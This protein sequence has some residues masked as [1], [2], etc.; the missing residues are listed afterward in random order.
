MN[1]LITKEI[2]LLLPGGIIAAAMALAQFVIPPFEF[3]GAVLLFIGMTVMAL[4]SIGRESSLNTFSSLLA[5][6]AERLRLWNV[7]LSVLSIMFLAA[8]IVWLMAYGFALFWWR[9][10]NDNADAAYYLFVTVCLAAVTTFSG[11]LWTTLLVRQVPAAFWLTLLAPATLCGF[12]AAFASQ[13]QPDSGVIVAVT[14]V[15]AIYSVG[16][17]FFARWL[18]L[19]AQDI[20]W[21]GGTLALPESK[22][23]PRSTHIARGT[24]KPKPLYALLKKEWQLQQPVT[25][26]AIG[27]LIL[28][29]GVILLR[30]YHQFPKDSAG[31][32]LTSIF[33]MLWLVL[34]VIAGGMAVAEERKLGMQEGQ[35]CLPRSRRIQFL[36]KAT[37]VLALGVGLGS[38]A[39]MLLEMIGLMINPSLAGKI[40]GN[41][42]GHLPLLALALVAF[43][44]GLALV[45]LYASS[46]SKNFLQAVGVTIVTFFVTASAMS[47]FTSY[48]SVFYD[49]IARGSLLTVRIATPT[50]MV[51][52]LILAYCNF[53]SI[54]SGWALWRRNLA[55]F[56]ISILFV[57][58]TVPATYNRAWEVF[59]PVEPAHGAPQLPTSRET[60]FLY[61]RNDRLLLQLSDGRVWLGEVSYRRPWWT[62][63]PWPENCIR[64]QFFPGSNWVSTAAAVVPEGIYDGNQYI[65]AVHGYPEFVGVRSDGT[66]WMSDASSFNTGPSTQLSQFGTE[67]NWQAVARSR[68]VTWILLLKNDGTLWRLGT[69][70]FDLE[71]WPQKW[72]GLHSFQPQPVGTDTNWAKLYPSAGNCL[73]KKTDGST[74]Y[75]TVPLKN[76]A[77]SKAQIHA[78]L[79]VIGRTYPERNGTEMISVHPDG[80]LWL[81]ATAAILYNHRQEPPSIQVGT[82]TNWVSVAMSWYMMVALKSDGTLWTWDAHPESGPDDLRSPPK[83]L[84]IHNDWVAMTGVQNGIVTLATDGSLWYWPDPIMFES[85]RPLLKLPKQPQALGNIFKTAN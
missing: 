52:F 1:P 53:K 85:Q 30:K 73:A 63:E 37:V 58:I 59:E 22:W 38:I 64:R 43:S 11:G 81:S 31:E 32:V 68:T 4:A 57:V 9:P 28:H 74:W 8:F 41:M 75:I 29:T 2:R 21:S 15:V 78:D 51:T 56:V 62:F 67:T 6:P 83:R 25:T 19:R 77:T 7:K 55:G 24:R 45:S 50:L 47:A 12:T 5:Q 69:N 35:F 49:S 13:N 70:H 18:F 54:D 76:E 17:F 20:G 80:T 16:G 10:A 48:H 60:T 36:I 71:K 26:G 46:L 84:G 3:P 82:D 42:A 14:T 23:W 27:L 40:I 61:T 66:L 33:W 44:G 39:P 79:F 65:G 34:P 72:P